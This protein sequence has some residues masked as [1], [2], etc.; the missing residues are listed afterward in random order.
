[1]LWGVFSGLALATHYFAFFPVA[2]EA[3]WL[4]WRLRREALRGVAIVA[5][6]GVALTPL[7]LHQMS[8]AHAEWISSFGLWHRLWETGLTFMLGETGEVI[9]QPEHPLLA[10]APGLLA[11]G[12][13]LLLALRGDASD[14]RAAGAPLA[15][16]AATVAAPVAIGLLAPSADFVLARNLLP[17][18]VPLLVAVAIGCTLPAA[19]RAGAVLGAA[20]V[21]YSLGFSVWASISPALQRPN[22]EA[23]AAVLGEPT[24]PRAMVTWT[25]GEA[26]LRYYLS[27]GSFQPGPSE[28][29]RWWV[30]EVDFVSEG[31][32]PPPRRLLPRGFRQAGYEQVG[33][34]WVRRYVR[35][36]PGLAPLRLNVVRRAR[37]GFRSNSVLLDGI[38]PG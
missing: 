10:V 38:G 31:K 26:P 23:V 34:L 28:G 24:T 21:A 32:A 29:F 3:L 11:A 7:V 14:R 35:D 37:L 27:T 30:G 1:V 6:F 4:L 5:G 18:L 36:A 16:T 13:L 9:A 25:I 12:V 33:R 19:R 15:I 22:W 2:A 17:A 20:L 8:Y